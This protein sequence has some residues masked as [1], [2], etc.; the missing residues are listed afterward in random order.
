MPIRRPHPLADFDGQL[1]DLVFYHCKGKPCV[2]R[3]PVREKPFTS[4]EVQSQARFR[5]ASKFAQAVLKD[6]VQRARY[7]QAARETGRSAQNLAVS[8]FLLAPSLAE[9]DL[10]GY[11]GRAGEFIKVVAKEGGIGAAEVK[12]II[13]DAAKAVLEEGSAGMENDGL[14]WAYPAKLDLPP[15]QPV[16]ITV[17]A[18]DQPGNRTTRTLR[19]TTGP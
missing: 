4:A 7:Q 13:A 17:T 2:R 6:P 12:V 16:W 18:A 10:S 5:L 1:G 15:D 8:D 19:H 11:T 14:S 3:A 9:I